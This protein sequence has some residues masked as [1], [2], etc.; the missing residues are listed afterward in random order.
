[1]LNSKSPVISQKTKNLIEKLCL[2]KLSLT[3]IAKI[4]GISEDR[5]LIY[6]PA[7]SDCVNR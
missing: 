3:Q 1:M 4:T 6:V 2:G 7:N 5:L